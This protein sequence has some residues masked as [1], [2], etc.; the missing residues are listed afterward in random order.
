MRDQA[1]HCHALAL[2][3]RKI[4]RTFNALLLQAA[5]VLTDK[6]DCFRGVDGGVVVYNLE[7]YPGPL[8][9]GD[10]Y[11]GV[12]SAACC[13]YKRRPIV[14]Y[15]HFRRCSETLDRGLFFIHANEPPKVPEPRRSYRAFPG[16]SRKRSH[17]P[18][19]PVRASRATNGP[20]IP[21]SAF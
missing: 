5:E 7:R 15:G 4:Y 14:F 16:S 10:A 11:R 19:P 6:S 1:P 17:P 12:L 21:R 2:V 13:N 9:E 20:P 3:N 8:S 18:P